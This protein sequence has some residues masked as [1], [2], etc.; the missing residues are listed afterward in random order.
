MHPERKSELEPTSSVSL[1]IYLQKWVYRNF[2]F[3]E[4]TAEQFVENNEQPQSD[5]LDGAVQSIAEAYDDSEQSHNDEEEQTSVA[6]VPIAHDVP[7]DIPEVP[8]LHFVPTGHKKTPVQLD[9]DDDEDDDVVPVRANNRG[10]P[11]STFFPV[12]FGSTNGGAIAIANSYSTGKG[13][14]L[15]V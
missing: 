9:E 12:S 15:K 3:S 5:T 13:E 1:S 2:D 4:E 11:G 6:S 8:V 10:A 7:E 14:Q